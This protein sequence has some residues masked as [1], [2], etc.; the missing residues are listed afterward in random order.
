M[1][2]LSER[3]KRLHK[4][5]AINETMIP[6]LDGPQEKPLSELYKA[7][8]QLGI[9]LH[10]DWKAISDLLIHD[11][12]VVL[13]GLDTRVTREWLYT[14]ILRLFFGTRSVHERTML[15]KMLCE[16]F[17]YNQQDESVDNKEQ[18]INLMAKV[19]NKQLK[20]KEKEGNVPEVPQET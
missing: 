16:L 17:M 12:N 6:S 5:V 13:E 18:L 3:D 7:V 20:K 9:V 4:T 19:A 1:P 15:M 8:E 10:H 2:D 14:N 11:D